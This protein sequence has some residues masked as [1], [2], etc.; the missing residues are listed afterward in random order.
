MRHE[1]KSQKVKSCSSSRKADILNYLLYGSTFFWEIN[2]SLE[3]VCKILQ[4]AIA[5]CNQIWCSNSDSLCNH[6]WKWKWAALLG[7]WIVVCLFTLGSANPPG[8]KFKK[9]CDKRKSGSAVMQATCRNCDP[10]LG[11]RFFRDILVHLYTH[12]WL[13]TS[14]FF[15]SRQNT[16]YGDILKFISH[17]CE[18]VWVWTQVLILFGCC[19]QHKTGPTRGYLMLLYF[20]GE[21]AKNYTSIEN[22]YFRILISVGCKKQ[23]ANTLWSTLFV[24]LPLVYLVQRQRRHWCKN[25]VGRQPPQSN[26]T[27]VRYF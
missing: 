24:L 8:G 12:Y 25:V 27:G 20:K 16:H 6:I 19:L 11:Y 22:L 18:E 7:V 9:C 4:T 15:L 17:I 3:P 13:K 21:G 1:I 10:H 26:A 23:D 14:H 2:L 5:G